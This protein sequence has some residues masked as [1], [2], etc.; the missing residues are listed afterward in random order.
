[1]LR[2]LAV[3]ARP[4]LVAPFLCAILATACRGGDDAATGPTLALTHVTLVDIAAG[5]LL[6]E[7]TVV[8]HG[9]R[10]LAAGPGRSVAVPA[11]ARVVDGRGR[12]LIPGLWD[13]HVH[14]SA[15]ERVLPLFLAHGVTGVRDMGN[16]PLV[17]RWREEVE[18]GERLGPRIV[19][20]GPIVDG[21][22]PSAA[23]YTFVVAG[24]E[25]GRRAVTRLARLGADCVKV[26]DEVPRAAYHAVAE[27]ARRR[28]LP[29]VGHVPNAVTLAEAAAA[30]QVTNE[31]L[32][33]LLEAGSRE[34]GALRHALLH[35]PP[36]ARQEDIPD[37][38]A[39][40]GE[41]AL[42]TWDAATAERLFRALAADGLAQVPTLVTKRVQSRI[43]EIAAAPDPRLRWVSAYDRSW[44]RPA[45]NYLFRYRTPAYLAYR[46]RAYARELAL[47]GELHRAGVRVLAGT[48]LGTPWI[49]P[50]ASLHDELE[51]LVEA[52]L[53][54]RAALA[55]ATT[56]PA[57]VEETQAGDWV[58]LDADPLA[59][60]RNV[61]RIAGVVVRG[62]WLDR[63]ALDGLLAAAAQTVTSGIAEPA[64]RER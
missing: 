41:R 44:W 56:T 17:F 26:Y 52:G 15:P 16:A 23:A 4:W 3:R 6:P 48:D 57:G 1:V 62:R 19:A 42:A 55:A 36:P 60:I 2:C 58:L 14:I 39:A 8:V 32:G 64:G 46:H 28:G 7:R 12:Y 45:R 21:P 20:C 61:R 24:P 54:P 49:Y 9:D 59:D 5:A 31:H 33:G 18:R 29:L 53:P 37:R 38:I 30:G 35:A 51:L 27:E 13:H 40:R 25:D 34:A 63:A 50:G 22:Q 43:D 10:L 11:G 47:V